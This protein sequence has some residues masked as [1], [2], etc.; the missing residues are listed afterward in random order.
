MVRTNVLLLRFR[1]RTAP[2]AT[3]GEW[4][5]AGQRPTRTSSGRSELDIETRGGAR[6]F[7]CTSTIAQDAICGRPRR[8]RGH[9]TLGREAAIRTMV[10]REDDWCCARWMVMG[11]SGSRRL[12]PSCLHR[13][14]LRTRR[15]R[16]LTSLNSPSRLSGFARLG[17]RRF[18][19]SPRGLVS[20]GFSAVRPL[21]ASLARHLL[22]MKRPRPDFRG[23]PVPSSAWPART[24]L[25]V[26]SQRTSVSLN[27]A[28]AAP[29]GVRFPLGRGN[30]LPRPLRVCCSLHSPV[31]Y[32]EAAGSTFGRTQLD[33]LPCRKEMLHHQFCMPVLSSW[34]MKHG[35]GPGDKSERLGVQN[36]PSAGSV[37]RDPRISADALC[38]FIDWTAAQQRFA[39]MCLVFSV[40]SG[41]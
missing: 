16:I 29:S 27:A 10:C 19:A 9:C 32:M 21:A 34:P 31:N 28:R 39:S 15:A 25:G 36:S 38:R 11:F 4:S 8:H 30:R 20:C 14:F 3:Q 22:Q 24:W 33:G 13:P 6:T 37:A 2:L 12:H 18:S 26:R 40:P 17:Q 7:G 41:V 35:D 5:C 23:S 1:G